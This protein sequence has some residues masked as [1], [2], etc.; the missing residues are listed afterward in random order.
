M[1]PKF[2]FLRKGP[3]AWGRHGLTGP[4]A[5]QLLHFGSNISGQEQGHV[6]ENVEATDLGQLALATA[7]PPAAQQQ[8]RRLRGRKVLEKYLKS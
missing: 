6:P 2:H 7:K 8:G 1:V 3:L 5:T 4:E